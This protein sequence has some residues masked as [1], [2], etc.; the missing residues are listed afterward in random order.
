[1]SSSTDPPATAA[2]DDEG[3]GEPVRTRRT[4]TWLR[5]IGV[6]VVGLV[7]AVIGATILGQTTVDTEVGEVELTGRPA[8]GGGFTVSLAPLGTI[9]LPA[10]APM[11]L[12]A[13]LV[14]LDDSLL[15]RAGR[16]VAK[17]QGPISQAEAERVAAE[18]ADRI[19]DAAV[20]LMLRTLVG[21]AVGGALAGL[22]VYRRRREVVIAGVAGLVAVGALAVA[23]F[24][25]LPDSVE[26]AEVNGALGLL[27]QADPALLKNAEGLEEYV[28]KT[29][30]NIEGLYT[31]YVRSAAAD[32]IA[33]TS[34]RVIA[35]TGDP[36]D[37]EV[38]RRVAVL[39][40]SQ[41]AKG[42]LWVVPPDTDVEA[43]DG[44]P[45]YPE[46]PADVSALFVLPDDQAGLQFLDRFPV[47]VLGPDGER[48]AGQAASAE[49]DAMLVVEVGG[50]TVPDDVELPAVST[51]DEPAAT[52]ARLTNA[53]GPVRISTGVATDDR[54]EGVV[55]SFGRNQPEVLQAQLVTVADGDISMTRVL[56]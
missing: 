31:G 8:L 14:T 26:D 39:A 52:G 37:D 23:A 24:A 53:S 17:G 27:P 1:M 10:G 48:P 38:R 19:A 32:R 12:Q 46:L 7:G 34:D 33:R 21:G 2:G 4:P 29:F 22:L 50:G 18:A 3:Q 25:T 28:S 54:L 16:D 35:I 43:V 30:R 55:I 15:V 11:H 42:V 41:G 49:K 40:E 56:R 6:V 47:L 51:G 9:D 44:R 36:T 5:W 13:R 45:A 20:P